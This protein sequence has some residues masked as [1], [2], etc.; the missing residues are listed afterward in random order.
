MEPIRQYWGVSVLPSNR[1]P[2][3]VVGAAILVALAGMWG[4]YT[5][6]GAAKARE[7]DERL[8][9]A[10]SGSP[11][12]TVPTLEVEIVTAKRVA[13]AEIVELTGVLE[14]IRSTWVAA[15][16]A[17]RIIEVPA[18]E[19]APIEAGGLLVQ[20]DA[21]LAEAEL[22]RARALHAL[23]KDELERQQRLGKHSVAS[24]ADL[25]RASAEERRSYA[26][27]LEARARLAYTRITSPFDGL[28]NA[29]D[30]DPGAYVQPGTRIAEI[31]DISHVEL[32]VLVGDRQIPALTPGVAARVRVDP[33][34]NQLFEGRIVRVGRA[35]QGNTQRYPVVVALDNS[36]GLLFPGML[37]QV[38]IEVGTAQRIRVPARA[39]LREFE[40][41]Y[42]FVLDEADASR[43]VR[44]ATRP[45]PFR[46]DQVEIESGL[47][48]GDRIVVTAVHQ[49]HDGMRVRVR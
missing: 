20:L 19:Y 45:I 10:R 5:S 25:D 42:V 1:T 26:G 16:V 7:R 8:S 22:I 39:L 44:V 47:S 49:L 12:E 24:E 23:A 9:N 18:E 48:E 38:Q 27:L 32:T 43:R 14:P 30:L 46:P 37:A 35:P 11:V 13:D 29:L 33:L 2:I 40:L 3:W 15:E 28:V 31:L 17:G 4:L 21:A 41:D 34:G 6:D 36:R